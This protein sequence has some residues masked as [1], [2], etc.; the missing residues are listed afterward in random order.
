MLAG[1]STQDPGAG[2]VALAGPSGSQVW[3][4]PGSGTIKATTLG[5]GTICLTSASGATAALNMDG[6]LGPAPAGC[7][8]AGAATLSP[9]SSSSPAHA[10]AAPAA[11]AA[12][13]AVPTSSMSYYVFGGNISTC[14]AGFPTTGCGLYS[15]GANEPAGS[16]VV[17]AF[18]APCFNDPNN[19]TTYGAQVFGTKTCTPFGQL[20]PVA[21]AFARG[22]ISTHGTGSR[23][24]LS[25]GTSNSLTA[26]VAGNMLSAT[27]ME[28]HADQW[29]K[30]FVQPLQSQFPGITV[31]AG[32]DIE[33]ESSGNF[34]DYAHTTPWVDQY[35]ISSGHSSATPC[36]A[37]HAGMMADFGDDVVGGGGWT[38]QQI[39]HVAYGSPA[40][41]PLPEIYVSANATEWASLA[42]QAQAPAIVFPGVMSAGGWN[43]YLCSTKAWQALAGATGQNIP[44]LTVIGGV[45]G[46][47]YRGYS[48]LNQA[49]GI[50]S[51]GDA[52]YYGNLIDH[53][54]PG[55]AIGLA[56][57][58]NGGGYAILNTGGGIYTFGNAQYLGNLIDH[59]YPGPAVA[60]S[61]TPS[62]RGYAI[63]TSS[64][65]LYTFGDALYF[66]NLLDHHFPGPAVSFAYTP[67]GQGYDILTASGAIYT[68]GDGLYFGNL[69]DHGYPG[70]ATSLT[71]SISTGAGYAI[72]TSPGGLFTFGDAL[73]LGNLLD[74][75]YPGPAVAVSSTP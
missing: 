1:S 42:G 23:F 68:F 28:M 66:G 29:Y 46:C 53:H 9:A 60:I 43:G 54:Y 65:A 8:A 13:S 19:G 61:E 7:G 45:T 51:F 64:G 62:G 12:S 21:N 17:L 59:H 31:W 48:I 55:P 2:A 6:A 20:L 56:S 30:Q 69:L 3:T 47:G 14:G 67:D 27:Q 18:G 22:Y 50:Y 25:V 33:E 41:C 35:S 37:A 16:L 32:S 4:F 71:Y 38:P 11:A 10:A 75:G 73:Y 24:I 70:P 58:P 34:Y 63:L 72:L 44:Y 5:D 57:T 52:A 74:H 39:Y 15:A 26:A 49:G 40:S 36:D